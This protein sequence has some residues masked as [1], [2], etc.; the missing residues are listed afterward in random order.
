MFGRSCHAS[1]GAPEQVIDP[2][3]FTLTGFELG[4]FGNSSTGVCDGP[5]FFR[6]DLALYKT[7]RLGRRLRAELRFEVFNVFDNTQFFNVITWM[8]PLSIQY[9]APPETATRV[10]G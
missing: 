3:A 7:I 1:G 4:T 8:N 10:I 6:I 5:G 9:D 2:A